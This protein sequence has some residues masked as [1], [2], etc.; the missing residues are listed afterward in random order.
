MKVAIALTALAGLIALVA[1]SHETPFVE[2]P[3]VLSGRL[4]PDG[5]E[6]YGNFAGRI[7][8]TSCDRT[9][10][11][12]MMLSLFQRP[13][14]HSPTTY[15]LERVGEDGN[16]RLTTRGRWTKTM[17]APVDSRALVIRLDENTPLQFTRYMA[18]ADKLLLMLDQN[19]DLLVGNAAWSYTLSKIALTPEI[20]VPR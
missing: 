3:T 17:G 1:C 12:K 15:Q 6:L 18:I 4:P 2:D 16:A 19:D 14:D 11:I 10:K 5:A 9:D 20:Q 13:G 7:P 8:C